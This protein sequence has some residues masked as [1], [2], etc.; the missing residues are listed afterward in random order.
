[1]PSP[2]TNDGFRDRLAAIAFST[3]PARFKGEAALTRG[4]PLI[5]L[6]AVGG[7]YDGPTLEIFPDPLRSVI[8]SLVPR[9]TAA[10]F[11]QALAQPT[12][13]D[14]G[15][16]ELAKLPAAQ[17]QAVGQVDMMRNANPHVVSCMSNGDTVVFDKER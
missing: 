12:H 16:P 5:D 10:N 4:F 14:P 8:I 9:L 6:Q 17:R 3:F 2:G 7:L 11:C 13:L 15:V 1:S